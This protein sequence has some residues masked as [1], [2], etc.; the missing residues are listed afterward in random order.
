MI[1]EPMKYATVLLALAFGIPVLGQTSV[2][3]NP[4]TANWTKM[5]P[6]IEGSRGFT[7]HSR[8]IK[9]NSSGSYELW[10]K[11]VPVNQSAFAR[12][13]D[14]PKGTEH[15]IQ[16]ATVDCDKR[17]VLLE[18]TTAYD[19]SNKILSGRVS[20]LTPSSKKEAVKPGSIGEAVYRFVCVESTSIPL[21]KKQD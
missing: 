5:G 2:E 10:V 15:I 1:F 20:G 9:M 11:I 7:L 17:L 16:Y 12:R 4:Q 13:Y 19:S 8:G 3:E 6:T 21:P 18:R 14:L